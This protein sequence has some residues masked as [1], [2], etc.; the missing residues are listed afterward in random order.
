VKKSEL[1]RHNWLQILGSQVHHAS[2]SVDQCSPGC[3]ITCEP[4]ILH[5]AVTLVDH[6]Q[7]PG[8]YPARVSVPCHLSSYWCHQQ[9]SDRPF[10]NQQKTPLS[11]IPFWMQRTSQTS[12]V[13]CTSPLVWRCKKTLQASDTSAGKIRMMPVSRLMQLR[14][15][16]RPAIRSCETQDI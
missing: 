1:D 4:Y 8:V 14:H 12:F 7:P 11:R 2:L 16:A 6:T 15:C 10:A 3:P 9:R 5:E 13:S